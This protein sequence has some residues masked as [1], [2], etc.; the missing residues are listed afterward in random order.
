VSQ[1]ALPSP[2]PL[3]VRQSSAVAAL[4]LDVTPNGITSWPAAAGLHLKA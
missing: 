4:S 2:D 1:T 3:V